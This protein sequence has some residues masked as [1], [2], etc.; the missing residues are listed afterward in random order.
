MVM[1]DIEPSDEAHKLFMK[2][3]KGGKR[4]INI[5]LS[6]SREVLTNMSSKDSD[7]KLLLCVLMK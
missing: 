3:T 5:L 7:G 1:L 6:E 2:E 4:D